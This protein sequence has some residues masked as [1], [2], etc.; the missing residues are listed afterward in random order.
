MCAK[1]KKAVKAKTPVKKQVNNKL[2]ELD[3]TPVLQQSFTEK[4]GSAPN[5]DVD[6]EKETDKLSTNEELITIN[7]ELQ[8]RN[9]D[10]KESVEY[11]E[12]IVQTIRDPLV[13]LHTDLRVRTANKAFYNLFNLQQK[14][15]GHYFFELAGGLLDVPALRQQLQETVTKG[16][17][18]QDFELTHQF[19][20]LG[21]KTLLFNAMRMHGEG[22][23]RAR[24]LLAIGNVTERKRAEESL[25]R[26]VEQLRESEERLRV[27]MEAGNMG[28]WDWNMVTGE[29]LWSPDHN[30]MYGIPVDRRSGS[31][32][33][34]FQ[35]I[36]PH[37]RENVA[38]AMQLAIEVRKDF[39]MEMRSL[40]GNGRTTWIASFGRAFYNEQGKAHR[41]IGVVID[42]T[43]RKRLENQKEEFI[44]IASHELRTPVT[45]I[46]SYTELLQ[47][48]L[49]SKQDKEVVEIVDKLDR[50]IDR[51]AHL[52]ADLLD[53]TRIG[54]G[55]LLLHPEVFDINT[56]I[57]EM[58]ELMQRTTVQHIVIHELQSLPPVRADRER[59]GQV[60][61]NLLGNAIKY[62]PNGQRII[63]R[64][65]LAGQKIRVSIQDFGIGMSE[66]TRL[67]V[68]ERFFR[69]SDNNV[70]TYPGLGL[71]LFI[72]ADIVKK[73][74]GEI[75]VESEQDKGTV[76]HFTLPIQPM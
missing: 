37:D 67:K 51:L 75:N 15:D 12:A 6:I 16:I 73:H 40:H 46:K 25:R 36:H 49:K 31:Y 32:Q 63:I 39:A 56:L 24:I 7:E 53:I 23:K 13:V 66:E 21:E 54:E 65:E 17:G 18:F 58:A 34:F 44:G 33:E 62:S 2:N 5:S 48:M 72:A 27:A 10:L 8:L 19:R 59:I 20:D 57:Y 50:Q 9:A 69:A 70:Q 52:I 22:D 76:V 30:V 68:F 28:A 3:R 14:I 42:I 71:G 4:Q 43:D 45:S 47:E 35:Y 74:G 11:T 38:E 41:M 26:S 61:I 60:L 1:Q 55:Q 64:S 29:I